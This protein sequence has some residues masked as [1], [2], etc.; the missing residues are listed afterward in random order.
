MQLNGCTNQLQKG[1]V[2][3]R[4]VAEFKKCG[5]NGCTSKAQKGGGC[6]RH[7]AKVPHKASQEGCTNRARGVCKR[8]GAKVARKTC[9]REGAQTL[10][11]TKASALGMGQHLLKGNANMHHVADAPPKVAEIQSPDAPTLPGWESVGSTERI[12]KLLSLLVF[13]C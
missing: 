7:G 8:H 10:F 5:H 2:C 9:R 6:C 13:S 4:H 3:A 12:N 1:G 11:R